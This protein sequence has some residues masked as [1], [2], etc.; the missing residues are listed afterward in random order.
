MG[1]QTHI[2]IYLLIAVLVAETHGG[3]IKKLI[4]QRESVQ[5]SEGSATMLAG[6]Q[7]VVY[8]HVYNIK[9]PMG[10]LCSVD[11]DAPQN[12]EVKPVLESGS[13]QT[14]HTID[15]ENQIVFT[16]KINIPRQACGCASA[17]DIKQ[18]LARLEELESQVSTLREQCGNGEGCCGNCQGTG[19][20][21]VVPYCNG[22]GNYSSETGCV[23]EPGWRGPNCT[24]LD[25]IG[26]CNNRGKCIDGK[27]VCDEGF[28]GEDCSEI[29]CLNDCSDQGR[30]V[31]GIC[32][33]FE[34]FSGDDCS[35]EVCPIDCGEH[36]QCIN[37]EC[38]CH[39]GYIGDDCSETLC[40]NNCNNR[41]RCIENE[42]V[43]DEGFTGEDCSELICPNDCYDR[44]RCV[45]GTCYCEEGFTGEDCGQ[46]ACPNNCNNHGRCVNGQCVCN[47][48]FMGLDCS[49]LSCLNNCH[50]RGRCVNGQCICDEGYIGD[51]CGEL[52][53]LNNCHNRGRC[54][55][56][57]CI[58]DE[59][60]TG[61]DCGELRCPNDCLGRGRCVNGQ[62][63]CDEGYTGEDCS[64]LTCPN[65][66]M[67][68]GRCINGQCICDE[69]YT[70]EGCSELTCPNNCLNR[71]RCVNGQCVCD[72]GYTGEDCSELTCPNNCLNRGRC[73]NGQCVCDEGYTGEDCSELTC[74]NNCL[75]R[76]RCVNGH[77]VCDEGYTGEDCSELT[78]PN[79]CLN[80]GR[81]VNGQC[82]CDEGYTGE[83]CSELT[84]P[85]NC[86]NRGRCVNGQCVC[87]EGYTGEDCSE[88]T[89][90]DNCLNRGR[91][92]NG[93]CICDEGYTGDNCGELTCPNNCN[94]R[95]RCVNGQCICDADFIGEDCGELRCPN[96]C[97]LQGQCVNGQCICDEGFV[98]EDCSEVSPPKNLLVTD[99]TDKTINLEWTNERKVTEYLITY[100]PTAPGGLE[101]DFRVPG[102]QTTALVQEL[103]PGIE[104]FIRV[105]AILKNKKSIPVSARV[106][107]HLPTPDGLR[108]K[109]IRD[110]AVQVEWDPLDAIFEAWEIK[111]KNTEDN[112][113]TTSSL[114]RPET[115]YLQTGLI[116]GHEYEVSLQVVKNNTRGPAVKKTVTTML[117]APSQVG[118]RDITDSTAFVTWFKPVADIDGIKLTYGPH[119]DSSDR[120]TV[121][122]SPD[123][124]QQSLGNLKPD[125]EYEVTLISTRGDMRSVPVTTTFTTELD[126]PKN[127]K[128]V[129]QTDLTITLEWKNS[130]ANVDSYRVRY[131]PLSKADH[132]EIIVPR[133]NQATTKVT[134]VGLRPGTEYGIGVTAIKGERESVPATINAAT[135]IDSPKDLKVTEAKD[136]SLALKWKK[137]VAKIDL[138]HL[139]YVTAAGKKA[140]V[141][142]PAD[143]E[144]YVLSGLDAGIEYT[145]NLIAERGRQKSKPATIT[146]S[147][148][149]LATPKTEAI[150]SD[151]TSLEKT[152]GMAETTSVATFVVTSQNNVGTVNTTLEYDM[153]SLTVSS[154]L[155]T[156]NG[157]VKTDASP[158]ATNVTTAATISPFVS[159]AVWQSELNNLSV[160]ELTFHS[161]KILWAA[162]NGTFDSFNVVI[163][164]MA[165]LQMPKEI[166]ITGDVRSVE[167]SALTANTLFEIDLYGI[168]DGRNVTSQHLE[169]RTESEPELKN[170]TVS[171]IKWE[172]FSLYWTTDD[173]YQNF[174]IQVQESDRLV[175]PLEFVISGD[176]RTFEVTGLNA[177]STYNVTLQGVINDYYTHPLFAEAST[178]EEGEIDTLVVSDIT[179]E[180]F[181]LSWT[182]TEGYFENFILEIIDSNRLLEPVEY[183][184]SGSFNSFHISGLLPSTDYIAYLHGVTHGNRHPAVSTVATTAHAPELGNLVISNI[185]SYS[186]SLNWEA[187]HMFDDFIVEVRDSN[188]LLDQLEYI[189]PGTLRS[190]D[191]KNL[192]AGTDYYISLYGVSTGQRSQTLS[193]VTTT[194]AVPRFG[195]LEASAITPESFILSWEVKHEAF[196]N[197]IV[198]IRDTNHVYD[199]KEYQLPGHV[200]TINVTGLTDGTEYKIN[201]SG[202]TW[203]GQHSEPIA[204]VVSTEKM[205]K[206]ENLTV[207]DIHPYGFT[208]SWMALEKDF[209]EFVV[210]VVD[211]GR[212]LAPQIYTVSGAQQILKVT[213]LITGIGYEIKLTGIVTG[214]HTKPL[215]AHAITAEPEV[216]SLLVSDI[217]SDS[218][219]LS[220][221]TDDGIFDSFVIKIRD[222]NKEFDPLELTVSGEHRTKLITG[223]KADTEYEI[224]L[225]GVANG[226]RS[227]PF[228]AAVSTVVGSPK[229][230]VFSGITDSSVTASWTPPKIQVNSYRVIYVPRRGG[231]PNTETIDGSKSQVTLLNLTPDTEYEVR[232]I[233]IK[234]FEE[235]EPVSGFTTT[236][237]DAPSGLQA[238]NVTDSEA[239]LLWQPAVA[240]VDEY[241]I[242]YSARN[243]PTVTRRVSG[244]NVEFQPTNLLPTTKYLVRIYAV[245]GVQRSPTISTS[246]ETGLDAPK[247]LAASNIQL[248]TAFLTWKAPRGSITGYFLVFESADATVKEVILGPGV[249]SY[250]MKELKASTQYTVKLQAINGNIRSKIIETIF[251]TIGLLYPF[252]KD[253]SQALLNGDTTSGLYTIYLNGEE[254]NPVQVYC[255][256]ESDGGGWIVFLR[257]KNGKENF[258]RNWKTYTAGFGDPNEEFFIGLDNLNKITSQSQYELRVDLR[259]GDETAY[260]LYDAFN[261]AESRTRFKLTVGTYS[262]NAGDS[263]S[264]HQGRPFS[265]YDRDNDIAVTNCALSYKGAFWYRNCH[266]VNLMGQY[267][268]DRHSEGVNWFHWKGHEHSISFAEMKLR[269]AQFR[270]LEG[271]IRRS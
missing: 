124:N 270:N 29:L 14:E 10:S 91:C 125:T 195:D 227:Q 234:G 162:Q 194:E 146:A 198:R 160:T 71:G 120:T 147:T 119:A 226:R 268:V 135:D 169:L 51:D 38:V 183:N 101:L 59:G 109:T 50:N 166:S 187:Q 72:E 238:V 214:H 265:T 240:S 219:L 110:T 56:G 134:L 181:N 40:P 204:T 149:L 39:E 267:G 103:E 117:D 239:L 60:F 131:A 138:Y 255:D 188:G 247:D 81:C 42:C 242:E 251:T 21:S 236:S 207:S 250:D 106:A 235:S 241:V 228:S 174:V 130:R 108:F 25:C 113:D 254:S 5:P 52:A 199:M 223:L 200:T 127:L 105:F 155:T 36:G 140:E 252:P 171:D 83:D 128:K 177:S 151:A 93:Q 224:D 4:R 8:N 48:G 15:E 115:T 153:M 210:A 196:E 62:C 192:S 35:I 190:T 212:L 231:T 9:L 217:T 26:N 24:E 132:S 122:V 175:E 269:P 248:E 90:P 208:V 191:L 78:C 186:L 126:T 45:N 229:G 133:S 44:G 244:N 58:C 16:H 53:C 142:V 271:R 100:V 158:V 82:V 65:N 136:S 92:V 76:G 121:D 84:C 69:G 32:I 159:S 182:A 193:A 96:D 245:K 86:L 167:V 150:K 203:G 216:E 139:I 107:T 253:C 209:D 165:L 114:T 79:N 148:A 233:A 178:A 260:A 112:E 67:N 75:N 13:Q 170:L 70:G 163:R 41:G 201:V 206:L 77:C 111:F 23:C 232:V 47:E 102:D 184:I 246:F 104:Y 87:D 43:C 17:P 154:L 152:T 264:Y 2:L 46:L 54:V 180:S 202:T 173:T 237:I 179:S 22:K 266:R 89:C 31:N 185:T 143:A 258:Y 33:C 1:F 12:P 222:S 164:D 73:V 37:G 94:N 18:L 80:R 61:L 256:M 98:G 27:C 189:V 95:G 116:P 19:I 172:S 176:V 6:E 211:S 230:L 145:I 3:T 259:D 261:V 55:N 64:E 30:C 118:I 97:S 221:T 144:T 263:L 141:E 85:N 197:I 213:G 99:V 66:C 156:Q 123:N 49:E 68:R 225:Y 28:A 215:T 262:G 205:P 74:P 161:C 88:L 63:E 168:I 57:Q 11:L 157:E 137:P 129:S 257:R 20:I 243:A 7:P 218:F 34:G 249:L 220:W